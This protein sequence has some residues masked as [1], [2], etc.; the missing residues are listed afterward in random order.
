LDARSTAKGRRLITIKYALIAVAAAVAARGRVTHAL[1]R[2]V[3]YLARF[4]RGTLAAG[5][6]AVAIA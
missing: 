4:A 3:A 1:T 2:G 6:A 5:D